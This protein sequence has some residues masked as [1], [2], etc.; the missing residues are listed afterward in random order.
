MPT[1]TLEATEITTR[2][3][4]MPTQV[5][6]HEQARGPVR[7]GFIVML[8]CVAGFFVWSATAH[9]A[10]GAIASGVISPDGSRR[11][12]QHLEGG[13]VHEIKVRDGSIVK[14]GDPLLILQDTQAAAAYDLIVER[15]RTLAA[16]NARLAAEQDELG[17]VVYLHP[18][19]D[20]AEAKVQAI[21]RSQSALFA[22]RR[23]AFSAQKRI[24]ADRRKQYEEQ[25]RAYEVQIGSV[26]EQ[27][28]IIAQEHEG[29][30]ALYAKAL[31]TRPELLRLERT[32][33][34]L[35]GERGRYLGSIAEIGQRISEID[36]QAISLQA[37]RAQEVST[38][39]EEVRTE[40]ATVSE[41]LSA[42][43]D[44][45]ARTVISAPISGKVINLRFKTVGGVVGSGEPIL[46]IVP[47]EEG[48]LID[49]RVAPADIDTL[50]V[51]LKSVVHLTAYSS[52]SLPR[53]EGVVKSVSADRLVDPNTSQPY[54]L[55]RVEVSKEAVAAL[56]SGITLVPGMPAEVLIVTGER[57][58]LA[59]LVEPFTATFRRG[60]REQ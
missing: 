24:L 52:R 33:A 34:A 6:L 10:S 21:I 23:E 30:A 45:L 22:R 58:A 59:Y 25:V 27:R 42:S 32:Q 5:S 20:P 3:M 43:R 29:K 18:L 35:D 57:T 50:A 49:A 38:Q 40:L 54:F 53:I 41:Q 51:G 9:L 15:A 2:T 56:D 19:L 36:T 4:P 12:L 37:E 48:L 16:T 8:S 28:A 13:I 46:E 17:A 11:V 44:V 47:T 39:M 31:T 26:D 55:A 60:F 14:E 7:L 1:R